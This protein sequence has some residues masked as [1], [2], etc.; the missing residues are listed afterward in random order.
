MNISAKQKKTDS[1]HWCFRKHSYYYQSQKTA[2]H[3]QPQ[4]QDHDAWI[5]ST[6]AIQYGYVKNYKYVKFFD[7]IFYN[8]NYIYVKYL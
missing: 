8:K 3:S 7:N 2:H 4:K 1:R 5:R 6:G